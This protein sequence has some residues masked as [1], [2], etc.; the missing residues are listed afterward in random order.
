MRTLKL[1][2]AY[3]G[4]NYAGWQRQAN[5]MSVQQVLEEAFAPLMP[6]GV[7]TPSIAGAS[8]TDA[9]V[10]ALGQVA[11]LHTTIDIPATA[12]QRALNARLPADVRVIGAIDATPGFHARA[13]AAGKSYRYRVV[14][15]PVRSPFDRW[16]VH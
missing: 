1:T 12:I 15:T 7:Q 5:G 9:G 13:N 11:S 2:L 6:A 4:T 3:D 14:T 10:H 16:F 8:R